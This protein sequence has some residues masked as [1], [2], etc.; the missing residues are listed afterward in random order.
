MDRMAGYLLAVMILAVAGWRDADAADTAGGRLYNEHCAVCHGEK[1]NGKSRARYGMNPPPR[2]FT[3]AAAWEA[4]SR[5]R[6]LTSVSYG[7]PDTAMVAFKDR[8]SVA[9]IE[10]VVDYVRRSFMQAPSAAQQGSGAHLYKK[11]CSACHG[12]KGAG[13][14]WTRYSLNPAPRNFTA[15]QARQELSRERMITSVT[16]GRPGTAMM[17][18]SKRLSSEQ[19]ATVVSYIR[20]TFMGLDDGGAAQTQGAPEVA[21]DAPRVDMTLAFPHGLVGHSAAGRQFY[22]ANCATCHGRE[23][24]GRGVRASFINPP[25][26]D[27][28]SSKSRRS[29]NRPALFRAI[30]GGKRGTVMPAWGKVLDDQQI[31]DVAEYVFETFITAEKKTLN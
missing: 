13:A 10:A 30:S 11:H 17:S 28:T 15:P 14:T 18:F 20:S 22:Q 3:T 21:A 2:D 23:G 8:L 9:E 16:Y 27:F 6:M 1:G 24:D 4:L 19:I 12:D 31:A 7:R 5:E 25:P 26:R 29:Y